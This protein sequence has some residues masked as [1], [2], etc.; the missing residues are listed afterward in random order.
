MLFAIARI[1]TTF[2]LPE[3]VYKHTFRV[4]LV[5]KNYCPWEISACR[6]RQKQ[7]RC[8]SQGWARDVKA[9]DRDE[10]ET[11]A[12][13]AETRRLLAA[14][15]YRDVKIGLHVILKLITLMYLI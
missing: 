15:R 3:L 10:T 9:R 5:G 11:L 12:S 6:L 13:Q 8:H 1:I 7:P 14:K 4:L 2:S